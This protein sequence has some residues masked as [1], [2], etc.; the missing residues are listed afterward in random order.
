MIAGHDWFSPTRVT[1][2]IAYTVSFSACALRWFASRRRGDASG[3]WLLLSG[4]QLGLV[5]DVAFDLRWNLHAFWMARAMARDVYSERRSPQLLALAVLA[6]L[7]ILGCAAI[8][9]R[10]RR[11]RGVAVAMT[12]TMLSVGL[13]CCETLSYH[14]MDLVLYRT[15]GALMVV[16]LLWVGLAVTTLIGVLLEQRSPRSGLRRV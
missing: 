5:V 10:F 16:S 3:I 15:V 13:W 12:G 6:G 14:Y 8:Q 2:L 4:L 9:R 11:R 7:L 1:G